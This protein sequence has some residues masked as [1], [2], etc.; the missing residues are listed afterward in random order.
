MV[1]QLKAPQKTETINDG[2]LTAPEGAIR[3]ILIGGHALA[4]AGLKSLF[5]SRGGIAVVGETSTKSDALALVEREQPDI[6]LL[7]LEMSEG[8]GVELIPNLVAMSPKARLIALTGNQDRQMYRRAVRL[9]A[10]GLMHKDQPPGTL[11]K[12]IER[13]H[14]GEVWLDRSLTASVLG[15]ISR[16]V[17]AKEASPEAAQIASLTDRER[18][19][20]SAVGTGLKN[21]QI[22]DILFISEVTVRHHLTSI[23]SKLEVSNRLELIIYAYRHGLAQLPR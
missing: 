9:G 5:A 18:E 4:R 22:A 13:V 17:C 12:A 16:G 14:A 20:I 1:M 23:Y 8:G 21:K 15:E 19:V 7:D 10:M 11:I 6:I 3:V 2:A